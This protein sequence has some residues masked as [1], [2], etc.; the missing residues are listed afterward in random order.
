M[1][2]KCIQQLQP[3][4]F[5]NKSNKKIL[6]VCLCGI[7]SR[8]LWKGRP[9]T[10]KISLTTD[11]PRTKG[12]ED[13][14]STR[15]WHVSLYFSSAPELRRSG[16]R[17]DTVL[18]V[19]RPH[20]REQP[21]RP[22]VPSHPLEEDGRNCVARFFALRLAARF[23]YDCNR[24]DVSSSESIDEFSWNLVCNFWRVRK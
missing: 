5:Q 19:R 9:G 23:W 22:A 18:S 17:Q 14:Y 4:D 21:V 24:V 20:G 6:L 10:W 16:R 7:R 13:H 11:G 12:V 15:M 8:W 1:R 2:V 3:R